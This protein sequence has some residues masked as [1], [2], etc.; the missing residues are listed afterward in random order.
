MIKKVC[1]PLFLLAVFSSIIF[2]QEYRSLNESYFIDKERMKASVNQVQEKDNFSYYISKYRSNNYLAIK[3]EVENINIRFFDKDNVELWD[4][5]INKSSDEIIDVKASNNLNRL[6][7]Y[8]F[9]PGGSGRIK[10]IIDSTGNII[11]E[12]ISFK[13][14]SPSGKYL[15]N[16]NSLEL[17]DNNLNKLDFNLENQLVNILPNSIKNY[18]LEVYKD[19]IAIIYVRQNQFSDIEI[20]NEGELIRTDIHIVD[21]ENMLLLHSQNIYLKGEVNLSVYDLKYNNG[22]MIYA[23]E[24]NNDSNPVIHTDLLDVRS[25]ETRN[26]SIGTFYQ[27]GIGEANNLTYIIRKDDNGA[28][29]NYFN[30]LLDENNSIFLDKVKRISNLS[31]DDKDIL[32]NTRIDRKLKLHN[33]VRLNTEGRAETLYTGWLNE[34][35]NGIIPITNNR[36]INTIE[37]AR[38]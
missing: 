17:Y 28:I 32:I 19:D 13:D 22:I 6:I 29:L 34:E 4:R 26:V 3:E 14:I 9:Y 24:N 25:K 38:Q 1:M 20:Y 2:S 37:R 21:L 23:Y 5:V 27:I 35:M 8:S 11:S 16:K 33:V 7:I 31:V 30:S 18:S 15:Y 36:I 12:N 10:A